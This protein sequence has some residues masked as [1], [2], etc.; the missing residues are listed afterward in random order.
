MLIG[1]FYIPLC[2]VLIQFFLRIL[3]VLSFYYWKKPFKYLCIKN[4]SWFVACL[5]FFLMVNFDEQKFLI[6]KG[7]H[8]LI[9][10]LVWIVLSK[11][12][13]RMFC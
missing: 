5:L 12:N 6:L 4:I 10:F 9:L 8:L 1:H 2:E 3:M 7:P 11:T 13:L